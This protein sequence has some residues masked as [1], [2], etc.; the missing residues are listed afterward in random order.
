MLKESP[1]RPYGLTSIS[2]IY[3]LFIFRN[4]VL[5]FA[6]EEVF[7]FLEFKQD[8]PLYLSQINLGLNGKSFYENP[9]WQ[10][11]AKTSQV[12]RNYSLYLWGLMGRLLSI[13]LSTTFLLGVGGISLFF[14][15]ALFR[16][17]MLFVNSKKLNSFFT[18]WLAVI[19]FGDF[20]FRPSPTQW[21]LPLLI[22]FLAI[23]LDL[24]RKDKYLKLFLAALGFIF[25]L[26][27]ANPFYALWAALLFFLI[28]SETVDS[29]MVKTSLLLILLILAFEIGRRVQ[30]KIENGQDRELIERWG[31]LYSHFP[32]SLRSSI[33]LLILIA[34]NLSLRE[35]HIKFSLIRI[36]V[37]ISLTTFLTLQQNI[38]T[39]IWWEPESHY[40]YLVIISV[41]LTFFNVLNQL[42]KTRQRFKPKEAKKASVALVLVIV[43]LMSL[44]DLRGLSNL[45]NFDS[46]KVNNAKVRSLE[47]ILSKDSKETDLIAS[48]GNA[49]E[50][51][52]WAGLLSNRKFIWSH[53]GSL[54]SGTDSEILLRYLCDLDRSFTN[55]RDIPRI[56]LTQGHRFNNALQ[57][58]DKWLFL[59]RLLP[60][61]DSKTRSSLELSELTKLNMV[62]PFQKKSK[63]QNTLQLQPTKVLLYKD[64]QWILIP[65][66]QPSSFDHI[67]L[68]NLSDKK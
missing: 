2:I 60:E 34:I 8:A 12:G 23:I 61:L 16:L 59:S 43:V 38:I 28:L 56:E 11:Q 6:H 65:Y 26:V 62:L 19:V 50:E 31:L 41:I 44:I 32:G 14:I 40:L 21:A 36:T 48:L 49:S 45:Y 24:Y 9:F 42:L 68:Q 4:Q 39:G 33:I 67:F 20:A 5:S 37:I 3:L 1:I 47:Q 30:E 58:F 25:L 35:I 18:L 54:L 52:A 53:S 64:G 27:F 63:C 17:N 51:L 57:H 10:S 46:S 13:D 55:S 29:G 15:I 7:P 66:D 22:L